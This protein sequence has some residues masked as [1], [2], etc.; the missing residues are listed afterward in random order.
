MKLKHRARLSNPVLCSGVTQHP[1]YPR[2]IFKWGPNFFKKSWVG[3]RKKF[4]TIFFETRGS[5]KFSGLWQLKKYS[6]KF[7]RIHVYRQKRGPNFTNS[8]CSG[9]PVANFR[10]FYNW[11]SGQTAQCTRKNVMVIYAWLS[12]LGG[13][14]SLDTMTPS[15]YATVP[16]CVSL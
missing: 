13:P 16:A 3:G 1:E 12:R 2:Q 7:L 15:S 6:Q 14:P 9:P 10:T 5:K 8:C 11:G 4:R